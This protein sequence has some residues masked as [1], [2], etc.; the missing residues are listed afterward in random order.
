MKELIEKLEIIDSRIATL[1]IEN[2]GT[3]EREVMDRKL[4]DIGI[5]V[6]KLIDDLSESQK[7]DIC[8]IRNPEYCN[9]CN[10][11]TCRYHTNFRG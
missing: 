1:R 10:T 8:P 5:L 9:H 3:M 11:D 6:C 4:Y 2:H 7:K